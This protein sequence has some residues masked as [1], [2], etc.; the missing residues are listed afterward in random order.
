MNAHIGVCCHV[1]AVVALMAIKN[2]LIDP[3]NLLDNWDITFVDPCSWRMVTCSPD[4]YVSALGLPSQ[5][6]S[7]TLL[8]S[9]LVGSTKHDFRSKWWV[10]SPRIGVEDNKKN[11]RP[12]EALGGPCKTLGSTWGTLEELR[13]P[14]GGCLESMGR[15]L[16]RGQA[17]GL[18]F[19][20]YEPLVVKSG[21]LYN[22]EPEMPI[23]SIR[24]LNLIF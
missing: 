4:G 3:H 20:A 10:L 18:E 14:F 22:T 1:N 15:T 6:L 9:E 7:G 13:N 21:L 17:R 16:A 23:M 12:L 24:C 8:I 11:G 2:D 19:W 5:N